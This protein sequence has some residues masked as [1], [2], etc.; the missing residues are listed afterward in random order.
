MTRKIIRTDKA[1][2]PIGAYNQGVVASGQML[3]V[4]GQIALNPDGNIVCESDV[5][6]QTKQAMENIK[7]IL[8]AA[9]VGFADVVKT[10]V[11]LA[12]MNDFAAMNEVYGQYF[13]QGN[14][15][16][17]A[18]VEVSR[19]PKDLLVEIECIAIIG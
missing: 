14:E 9:G 4:G 19:L 10:T 16:A 15:P 13:E 12:N 8:A 17:R 2:K 18:A 1:P 7:A 3:F 5:A 6:G 11:F